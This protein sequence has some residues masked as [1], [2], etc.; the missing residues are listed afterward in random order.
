MTFGVYQ[1]VR[2]ATKFDYPLE[3]SIE[4]IIDIVDKLVICECYSED[5]TLQRILK[6][7]AKH[8]VGKIG[9]IQRNWINIIKIKFT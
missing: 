5:D 8:E 1:F 6:L 4:S 7:Q 3:E 9:W 2:N